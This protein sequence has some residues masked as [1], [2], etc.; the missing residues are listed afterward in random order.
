MSHGPSPRAPVGTIRR[1]LELTAEGLA[2][3]AVAE[4]LMTP[5]GDVA[6]WLREW[7]RASD[8]RPVRVSRPPADPG[9]VLAVL[10]ADSRLTRREVAEA[11]GTTARAVKRFRELWRLVDGQV[12]RR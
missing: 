3:S 8:G 2:L 4:R 10:S 5:P 12:V 1:A 11:T 6:R 7:R 9:L